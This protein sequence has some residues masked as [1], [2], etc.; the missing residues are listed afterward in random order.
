ML[1]ME[2]LPEEPIDLCLAFHND[3]ASSRGTK[4]MK[5]KAERAQILTELI[6]SDTYPRSSV[7]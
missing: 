3:I 6:T 5:G 4:D 1:T 2:H 7:E